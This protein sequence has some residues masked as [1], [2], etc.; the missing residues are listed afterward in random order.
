M[1]LSEQIKL[2]RKQL[3]MS[4]ADLADAIWVSRNTVSNWERGDTTP[5]IQSLVLMSALFGLSL[6]DHLG[7]RLNGG[8]PERDGGRQGRPGEVLDVGGHRHRIA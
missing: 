1:I 4:Q 6:D 7:Q 3:G 2:C 8:M 5:D